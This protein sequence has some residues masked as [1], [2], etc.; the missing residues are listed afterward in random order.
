LR[1]RRARFPASRCLSTTPPAMTGQVVPIRGSSSAAIDRTG[2][3][4]AEPKMSRRK[5]R[6]ASRPVVDA[7]EPH[8]GSDPRGIERIPAVAEESLDEGMEIG[9][10]SSAR[11]VV[12]AGHE[13]AGMLSAGT[14]RSSGGRIPGKPPSAPPGCQGEVLLFELPGRSRPRA[15]PVADRLHPGVAGRRWPTSARR[16]R[17]GGP[18]GSSGWGNERSACAGRDAIGTSARNSVIRVVLEVDGGRVTDARWPG[19]ARRR[20]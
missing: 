1:S 10:P 4:S 19:P 9:G 16:N 20:R 6:P 12:D 17:A 13:R 14:S 2:M 18:T 5:R 3:R 15:Y 11:P 8:S 7:H